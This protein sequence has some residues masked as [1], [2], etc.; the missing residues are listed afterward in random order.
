MNVSYKSDDI[1][2]KINWQIVT[3]RNKHSHYS[4]TENNTS[5]RNRKSHYTHFELSSRFSPL[6]N[7]DRNLTT[8]RPTSTIPNIPGK[9]PTNSKNTSNF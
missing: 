4:D 3:C 6:H 1:K 7:D 9:N 8:K 5:E 2:N